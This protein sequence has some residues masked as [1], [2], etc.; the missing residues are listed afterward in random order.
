[1]PFMYVDFTLKLICL[2]KIHSLRCTWFDSRDSNP[3]FLVGIYKVKCCRFFVVQAHTYYICV[4]EVHTYDPQ[5]KP[6][7]N[8]ALHNW[9]FRTWVCRYLSPLVC[10]ITDGIWINDNALKFSTS[11]ETF[12]TS[13]PT[14]KQW[15]QIAFDPFKNFETSFLKKVFK[16]GLDS[17]G[18]TSFVSECVRNF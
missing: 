7:R 15:S 13:H 1:M 18:Q 17:E 4:N 10:G 8:F 9:W 2:S 14:E 12:L 5:L 16:R 6:T 3:P 11:G